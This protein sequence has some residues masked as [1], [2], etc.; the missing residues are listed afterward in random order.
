MSVAPSQTM[1]PAAISQSKAATPA[2]WAARRRRSSSSSVPS[3]ATS[4]PFLQCG[5]QHNHHPQAGFSGLS[6][7]SMA[8]AGLKKRETAMLPRAWHEACVSVTY[9]RVTGPFDIDLRSGIKLSAARARARAKNPAIP[10]LWTSSRRILTPT[11]HKSSL[12]AS[13]SNWCAQDETTPASIHSGTA[14]DC[15]RLLSPS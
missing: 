3:W 1:V 4:S 8:G 14:R 6:R 5:V 2:A 13:R 9:M 15:C 11:Q 12:A 7:A 10:A